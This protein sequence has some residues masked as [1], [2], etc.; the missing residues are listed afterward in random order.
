EFRPVHAENLEGDSA[1]AELAYGA[2]GRMQRFTED[3]SAREKECSF[4]TAAK[5]LITASR[6]ERLQEI[7]RVFG[8]SSFTEQREIS[9][10]LFPHLMKVTRDLL[11]STPA[12]SSVQRTAEGI[13]SL[14]KL[15]DQDV[16]PRIL[17]ERL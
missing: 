8:K 16:T 2:P 11:R 10:R 13:L 1:S 7:D 3:S 17:I 12:T 9:A 14:P 15:L 4:F 5:T 6:S